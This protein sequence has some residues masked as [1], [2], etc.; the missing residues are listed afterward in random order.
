VRSPTVEIP[1]VEIPTRLLVFGMLDEHGAVTSAD[2]GPV[3]AACGSGSEQ[4]RSCLRRL[5]AEGV[6][7]RAGAGRSARYAA[8]P[9]GLAALARQRERMRRAYALDGGVPAWDGTWHLVGFAIP[10]TERPARDALRDRLVGLGGASIQGGLYASPHAWEPAVAAAA[11]ELGVEGAV[12]IATTTELRVGG[13]AEPREIARRLWPLDEIAARYD[14]FVAHFRPALAALREMRAR[15]EAL[16]DA[17]FLP[18]A[19]AMA[20]AFQ[21]AFDPDPLL[22][23]ALLP[24][25]WPG[26]AA[27]ARL[28][29]SR[30]RARALRTA[31][32]RPRLFQIVDHATPDRT[33]EEDTP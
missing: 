23:R 32:G 9:A 2:L 8:T 11:K 22:P 18:G 5:V 4:L 30:R 31:P 24:R 19:L 15:R 29:E 33:P 25:R 3:A 1:T 21:P 26:A 6:L 20:V 17:A 13:V 27:R 7:E 10:E 28:L 14:A 16:P 12:T